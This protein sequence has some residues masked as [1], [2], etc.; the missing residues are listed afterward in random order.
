MV[1]RTFVALACIAAIGC[2]PESTST[3][4][5]VTPAPAPAE[6]NTDMSGYGPC[7]EAARDGA[8]NITDAEVERCVDQHL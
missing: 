6:S 8:G 4:R 7:I 2:T 3:V 5:P 1:R